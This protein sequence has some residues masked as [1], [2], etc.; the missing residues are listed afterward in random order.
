FWEVLPTWQNAIDAIEV[1]KDPIIALGAYLKGGEFVGYIMYTQSNQRI[2]QIAVHRDFRR[3]G[4]GTALISELVRRYGAT[5]SLMNVDSTSKSL[6]GFMQRISLAPYLEQ[7]E[8]E[9]NLEDN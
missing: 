7:F 2:P 1:T 6:Q 5:L 4:I 3:K 9:L 8:M